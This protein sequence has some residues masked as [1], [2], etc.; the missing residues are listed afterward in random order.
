MNGSSKLDSKLKQF[1]NSIN[2]KLERNISTK[3]HTYNTAT[4]LLTAN[5][6]ANSTCYL[7]SAAPTHLSAAASAKLEI[8]DSGLST[9]LHLLI[10]LKDTS[11]NNWELNQHKPLINNIPSTTITNNK[12]L[13]TIFLFEFEKTTPV[14]LFSGATFDTKLITTMYTNMKVDGHVIKLILDSRSAG[15]IITRQLIDQLGRRVD[16]AASTKIITTNGATKTSIGEIDNFSIKVNSII[17]PIK[18]LVMEATQYQALIGNDWLSKVNVTLDWSMQELQLSQNEQHT[19]IPAMC[20][21]FKPTTM[22]PAPLIKFEEEEKKPT[23]E[24]YQVFWADTEYNELPPNER[25][26]R[27][28]KTKEVEPLPTAIYTSY[29]YTPTQQSSYY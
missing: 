6:L 3:L 13:D 22:P 5:L 16:C 19:C 1:S 4:N 15:S 12:S 24:A 10:T 11:P 23:W 8:V 2:Q 14:L 21:H 7:L 20:R 9:D 18:V 26:K 28:E 17:V 29:T 27:K 25:E